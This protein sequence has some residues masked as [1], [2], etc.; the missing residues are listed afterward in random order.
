MA[1]KYF[2]LQMAYKDYW[3]FALNNNFSS[4]L[5]ASLLSKSKLNLFLVGIFNWHHMLYK[6]LF[7]RPNK[8]DIRT[9]E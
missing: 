1:V 7:D 2:I 5:M 4:R 8:G 6:M 3:L 9:I